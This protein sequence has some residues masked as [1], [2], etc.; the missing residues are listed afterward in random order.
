MIYNTPPIFLDTTL[1]DGEQASGVAFT[2]DEKLMLVAALRD[3]GV[4]EFE[5]GTPAMGRAAIK[6]IKAITSARFGGRMISWCRALPSD[7]ELSKRCGVD[8]IHLSFPVSDKLLNAMGKSREWVLNEVREIVMRARDSF[9]FVSIGAQD[10]SRAER[11]FLESFVT[12]V[13]SCGADRV[14]LADTVGVL[15]PY[16]TRDLVSSVR[17]LSSKISIE[18]HAH[19]DLGMACAN[20][21]SAWMAGAD[22]LST[23]VNGLGERAGNAAMEEVVLA[24]EKSV[25]LSMPINKELLPKLCSYV[26]QIS[27]REN[28]PSKPVV[29]RL[30]LTHESDIHAKC[31]MKD[32]STYQLISAEEMGLQETKFKIG[33]HTGATTLNYFL[34]ELGVEGDQSKIQILLDEVRDWCTLHKR[35]IIPDELIA[36]YNGIK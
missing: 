23:T 33:K 34:R 5:V 3:A 10:A 32:R 28:S 19:N 14:R 35:D 8:G 31:L 6:E 11:Y 36:M 22:T 24:I 9:P 15:N 30:A 16:T 7:I 20:S 25:G 2:L 21:L 27:G 13:V 1:R 12:Q 4:E 26:E 18:F 17:A 29:G